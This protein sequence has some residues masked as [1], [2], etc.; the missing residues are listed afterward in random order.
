[1]SFLSAWA[2]LRTFA[3]GCE[4]AARVG[5]YGRTEPLHL[6]HFI[7]CVYVSRTGSWLRSR[8]RLALESKRRGYVQQVNERRDDEGRGDV[9]V[10][11]GQTVSQKCLGVE[12]AP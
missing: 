5:I 10:Y 12:R 7:V 3:Q 1:M 4:A 11:G 2:Q 6:D 8:H 9:V